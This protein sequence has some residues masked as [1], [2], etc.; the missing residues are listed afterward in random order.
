MC[1][2][3]YFLPVDVERLFL[4]R[5]SV[6]GGGRFRSSII[7]GFVVRMRVSMVQVNGSKACSSEGLPKTQAGEGWLGV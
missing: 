7:G 1:R 6:G 5:C 3:E 4:C 2:G